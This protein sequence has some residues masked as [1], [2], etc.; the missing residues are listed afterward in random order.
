MWPAGC[1]AGL[2]IP[3]ILSSTAQTASVS[4]AA[5]PNCQQALATLVC[6]RGSVYIECPVGGTVGPARAGKLLGL[7][8]D[9]PADPANWRVAKSI[10]VADDSATARRYVTDRDSPYRFYY[11]QL[12]TKMR[13]AGRTK[14]FKKDRSQSDHSVMPRVNAAIGGVRQAPE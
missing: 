1:Q 12:L 3:A 8:G 2:S 10:F 5:C 9:E 6:E 4:C 13:G 14:L 7:M 11:S